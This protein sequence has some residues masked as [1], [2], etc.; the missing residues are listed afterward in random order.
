MRDRET[1]FKLTLHYDGSAFRG[2]QVQP[3]VLTVQGEIERAVVRLAGGRR[4]VLGSGRTDAGVHATG[5]VA[6]VTMPAR[7]TAPAL[8]RSLNALLPGAIW[9]RKAETVRDGFHPRR[10]AIARSYLYRVGT[11]PG[12]A[13]PFHRRWCWPLCRPIDL[14]AAGRAADR[15]AGTH[16]FRAFAKA[17]Q[18]E[19]GHACRVTGARWRR[20]D[21]LGAVFEISANRFLHRMVRYLVGT[22]VDIA[23]GR[24]DEADMAGLLEAQRGQQGGS[25]LTTSPPAPPGGLFLT[26]V[27]Y[28]E[29]PSRHS[30]G[31]AS[32]P[33]PRARRPVHDVISS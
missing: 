27:E 1:R 13:S 20:W 16:E 25:V 12:A 22:M 32:G 30:T 23:L 29:N 31:D 19:R 14:E 26:R 2:W 24:R 18:P 33:M 5:Q 28:P 10:D 3:G 21:E 11:A 8:A 17:G 9:V 4:S 15:L 6:A 7:W